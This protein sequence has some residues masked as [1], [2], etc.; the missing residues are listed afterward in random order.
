MLTYHFF[1]VAFVAIRMHTAAVLSGW[2]PLGFL[3]IPLALVDMV[4][5][6]WKAVVIFL[7]L[8][9]KELY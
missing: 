8:L 4:L 1:N 6:L 3:K 7:P 9:R 2:G 5:I